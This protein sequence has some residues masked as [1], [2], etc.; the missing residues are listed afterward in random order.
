MTRLL[1]SPPN[2]F[3]ARL[4]GLLPYLREGCELFLWS[5]PLGPASEPLGVSGES[6]TFLQEIVVKRQL[7]FLVGWAFGIFGVY[8]PRLL[9]HGDRRPFIRLGLVKQLLSLRSGGAF[10]MRLQG[11]TIFSKR[12]FDR[13]SDPDPIANGFAHECPAT[14]RS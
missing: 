8:F 2:I 10:F 13:C 11:E 14:R 7:P 4:F 6:T 12:C 3:A 1:Q 9:A 5:G